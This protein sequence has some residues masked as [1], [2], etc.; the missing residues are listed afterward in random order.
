VIT[1]FG[2]VSL[3]IFAV[4]V[5]GLVLHR[6]VMKKCWRMEAALERLTEIETAELDAI[7][8]AELE[9]IT[10]GNETTPVMTFSREDE[11]A[12]SEEFEAAHADYTAYVSRFPGNVVKAILHLP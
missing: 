5:V 11:I 6:R 4:C 3:V 9:T 10:T 7:D 8:V 12:A 2:G 1:F